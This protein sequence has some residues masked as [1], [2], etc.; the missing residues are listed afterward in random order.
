MVAGFIG[1]Q[2]MKASK[3]GETARAAEA[4]TE[5]V[6]VEVAEK[7]DPFALGMAA[8][9]QADYAS[10]RSYFES[11]CDGGSAN[12]CKNLGVLYEN[13]QGVTQDYAEARRLYTKACDGGSENGCSDL[14]NLV[15]KGLGGAT[16]EAEGLRLVR[17][18]CAAGSQWGCDW[19]DKRD[20][21]R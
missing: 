18:G 21:S 20:Y 15:F 1:V 11:A 16:D 2:L 3:A 4:V 8:F 6:A 7:T 12:G 5:E 19:L 13:G 10:A 9:E 14:G 17:K